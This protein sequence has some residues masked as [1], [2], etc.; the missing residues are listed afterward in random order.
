VVSV[1]LINI[2]LVQKVI[3]SN[4]ALNLMVIA[5]LVISKVFELS[6]GL[7]NVILGFSKKWKIESVLSILSIMVALPMNI[8]FV[9]KWGI[10]GAAFSNLVLAALI[11]SFRLLVL[12][13]TYGLFPFNLNTLIFLISG[14]VLAGGFYWLCLQTHQNLIKLLLTF[15][16]SLLFI[17]M[18]LKLRFSEDINIIFTTLRNRISNW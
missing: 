12:F 4:I 2:N 11:F 3:G 9:G 15:L 17:A 1:I 5:L 14:L 13:R 7:S 10:L 16:Y 18:V 6:T 8:Y